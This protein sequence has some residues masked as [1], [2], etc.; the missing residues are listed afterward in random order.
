MVET[1]Y[2]CKLEQSNAVLEGV[3]GMLE[4]QGERY[5]DLLHN[6]R[7]LNVTTAL[8]DTINTGED[9]GKLQNIKNIAC[10]TI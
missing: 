5:V 6:R 4:T 2:Q 9:C 7:L 8:F 1:E 3:S 10:L